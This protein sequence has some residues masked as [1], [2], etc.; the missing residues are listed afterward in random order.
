VEDATVA[1][2]TRYVKTPDGVHI[3]YQV[4]GSGPIDLV[5]VMG[6]MTNIEAM[7][8]EP[9]LARM[10]T[11]LGTFARVILFD[12]RGCGLSDRV[13]LSELASLETRMDDM[14]AVMDAAGS[15]RAVLYGISEG[16]PMAMLYAATYPER[17]I[18]LAVFGSHWTWVPDNWAEHEAH[19]EDMERTWGTEEFARRAL[20]EWAAPSV[21]DDE[22][23]VRWLA[24]Y[25]RRAASPGAAVAYA[26]MNESIDVG[27]VLSSIRVPTI[28]LARTG[29]IG[30]PIEDERELTSRIPG[31]RLVEL[32][33]VDHFPWVGDQESLNDALE[34]FV[35]EARAD[36]QELDRMLATV[37]FTDIVGSTAR[38]A[39]LGDVAWRELRDRHHALVRGQLARFRGVEVDE[40]GDGFF[41]T[42][43]GP[44]RAARCAL[45]ISEGARD[46]GLEIR[47]G[48]HTGEV[49]VSG[50]K[51]SGIAI[52]V[53]ARVGA[54][55]GPSEVLATSTVKDL[56]AG[57]SLRFEEHG[58][59]ELKGV[60]G[61]WRVYRVGLGG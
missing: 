1:P 27:G 30:F 4:Y 58:E 54:M 23:T 19:L 20:A 21:A 60:P 6:W 32:T 50:D 2:E 5:I 44:I 39:E 16:G 59:H 35:K 48:L 61:A 31:A 49:D 52:V 33:G 25:T 53:G 9:S 40:T 55:A 18:A 37:L 38:S 43:D 17:T 13:P 57:S 11:R 14:R 41:A 36:E 24:A 45:A 42:F 46:L 47:A 51:V 56:V 7:W 12:K 22:R 10:L 29:D 15:E 28:V 26:R 8:E 34:Q 3:A